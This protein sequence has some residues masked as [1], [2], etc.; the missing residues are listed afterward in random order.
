MTK[1]LENKVAL[2]FGAGSVGPGWGNGR[3]SA[4]LFAREGARVFGSDLQAEAVE[5]TADLIAEE[6]GDVTTTTCD[7]TKPEEIEA[8]VRACLDKYGRIDVLMNNVG[9]S[10]PGGPVE[11]TPEVWMR[12]FDTNLHYVYLSCKHV[13]PVMERQFEETGTGGSIINLASIAALRHFGPDVAAYAASKAGVIKFG[14]VTAVQYAPK[15]IRVN[16]IVPGLMDTPL[17]S[18]R[19]AGQRSG[20]DVEGLRASRAAQV[21]MGHMGTGWDV[22]Y[23]ALFLASDESKYITGTEIVVDGGMS[24]STRPPTG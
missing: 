18:V 6:G 16:T 21:P 17:V 7:I 1:R 24:K 5:A 10:M 22:A 14:Q 11:M 12:Q 3:A 2:V 20:G 19:L 9:G 4:V 13:I 23:A 15:Q 8:T